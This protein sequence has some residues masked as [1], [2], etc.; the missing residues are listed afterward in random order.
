MRTPSRTGAA[1]SLAVAL[2]LGVGL[3]AGGC[4]FRTAREVKQA[5]TLAFI[6]GIVTAA[7]GTA[8]T[9]VLLYATGKDNKV[10]IDGISE[11]SELTSTWSFMCE[12]GDQFV[13]GAFT[14][15]NANGSRDAGEPAGYLGADAPMTLT[16]RSQIRGLAITLD[17]ATETRPRYPLDTRGEASGRL[18]TLRFSMGDVVTLDDPRFD[19]KKASIGMWTPLEALR[20]SGAGVFFLQPYDPK[21]IPVLFV[22]GIGGAPTDF[23]VMIE[24]LDKARFQ[25]WV[26]YYP[27]G[28]R[29]E[30]PAAALTNNLPRLREKLGFKTLYVVAH[31]MGGL[32][33]LRAILDLDANPRHRDMVGLFVSA[34]APYAGHSAVKWGLRLTPEPVPSWLDLEPGSAF[35][36][37]LERPLPA[38]IPFYLLF[39]FRRGNNLLLPMS[40]DSVVPVESQLPLWA[41]RDAV[42]SWGFDCEHMGILTEDAPLATFLNVLNRVAAGQR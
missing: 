13:V 35:L 2:T 42:R 20:S 41:Q 24:R 23:S 6:G 5:G 15:L 36:K 19:P 32:V 4:A 29:L 10:L 38:R 26:F 3:L 1:V 21:R 28:F 11:L 16:A 37:T 30:T 18:A 33:A 27:S 31:S 25:P 9:Y 17:R 34:A 12:E 40:S 22:H 8:G 14:D 39:S 7:D